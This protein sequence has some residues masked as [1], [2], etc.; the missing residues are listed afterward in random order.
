LVHMMVDADLRLI[1]DSDEQLTSITGR[2]FK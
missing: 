2:I 1:Q